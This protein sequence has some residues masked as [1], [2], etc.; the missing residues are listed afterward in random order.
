[1][2]LKYM[3]LTLNS[4]LSPGIA[5]SKASCCY[6]IDLILLELLTGAKV[7]FMLGS[8]TL[9]STLLTGTV[10]SPPILYTSYN[11]TFKVF[12]LFGGSISSKPSIRMSSLNQGRL[13]DLSNIFSPCHSEIVMKGILAASFRPFH[14]KLLLS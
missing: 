2:S 4:T 13:V 10:P 8:R 3:F 14:R 6:S 9:V 7:S 12:F 1:M 11:G 5:Y